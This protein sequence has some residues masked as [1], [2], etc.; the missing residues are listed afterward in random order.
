M[1]ILLSTR[2][3]LSKNQQQR[4]TAEKHN[5]N[6]SRIFNKVNE[7]TNFVTNYCN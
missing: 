2:C 5:M 4:G 1:C 6:M 3:K 7:Y